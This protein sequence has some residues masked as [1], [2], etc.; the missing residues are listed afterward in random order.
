MN[1]AIEPKRKDR[2]IGKSLDAKVTLHGPRELLAKL[3]G[4]DLLEFFIVSEA[5]LAPDS[6]AP[7]D[8]YASEEIEGLSIA[9]DR[10][11]GRKMPAPARRYDTNLGTHQDHPETCPALHAGAHRGLSEGAF[12]Q[13][14]RLGR[15]DS[16]SG[17][18]HQMD[19][20]GDAFTLWESRDSD[21]RLLQPDPGPPTW[22][23]P[24]VS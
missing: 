10:A 13:S 11:V 7:A 23:R 6:N 4:L 18:D 22:A 21:S 8:A 17:P 3:E 9:V 1:K 2:V 5:V 15:P 14:V 16:G 12:P 20:A 24:S 19:R